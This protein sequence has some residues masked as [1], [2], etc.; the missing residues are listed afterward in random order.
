MA[1]ENDNGGAK[2]ADDDLDA[3]IAKAVESLKVKHGT[4]DAA[5]MHLLNENHGLRGKNREL[6]D[7]VPEGSVVIKD[8]DAKLLNLYRELGDPKDVR[9]ALAE[10]STSKANEARLLKERLDGEAAELHGYKPAV[11]K[12]L[13]RDRE[14][15]IE[16]EKVN[17]KDARVAYV[18]GV[19]DKGQPTKTPLDKFAEA[20]WKE[21]LPSLK[22]TRQAGTP[23]PSDRN[24][25]LPRPGQGEHDEHLAQRATGRYQ[26]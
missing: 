14:I 20:E 18:M 4:P 16:N 6:T 12:T 11:L 22:A 21:F 17:G 2:G 9:K 3:R 8:E 25:P 26:I 24:T 1:G 7:R 13:A 15:V 10:G 23:Q 19:D 5:L